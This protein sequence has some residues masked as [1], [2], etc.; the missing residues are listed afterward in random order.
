MKINKVNIFLTILFFLAICLTL[1]EIQIYRKTV[2]K[3]E[4]PLLIWLSTG[5]F[6][7]PFMSKTLDNYQFTTNILL[8]L[9]YNTLTF[10]GILLFIFMGSNY[11]FPGEETKTIEAKILKTGTLG[12]GRR[13][14]NCNEQYGQVVINKIE[15][16]L[17]FPCGIEIQ[18]FEFIEIKLKKGKWGFDR[19]SAMEPMNKEKNTL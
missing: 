13:G 16:Q 6:I 7:T 8:H 15:K 5:L 19:I 12:R 17:I 3:F 11:Y 1:W 14:S 9:F 4:I 18:N 10:G 2:I